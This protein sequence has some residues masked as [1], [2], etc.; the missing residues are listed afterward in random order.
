MLK[1]LRKDEKAGAPIDESIKLVQTIREVGSLICN[2][3]EGYM[4]R[5]IT[6]EAEYNRKMRVMLVSPPGSN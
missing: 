1:R 2:M 4:A 6:F 5:K 3:L